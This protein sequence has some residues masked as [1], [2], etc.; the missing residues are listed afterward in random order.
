MATPSYRRCA[1]FLGGV[2]GRNRRDPRRTGYLLAQRLE[3]EISGPG[4]TLTCN[5]IVMSNRSRGESQKS[6]RRAGDCRCRRGDR[7]RRCFPARHAFGSRSNP[8]RAQC[9]SAHDD[10]GRYRSTGRKDQRALMERFSSYLVPKQKRRSDPVE[11]VGL[12]EV[13]LWRTAAIRLLKGSLRQRCDGLARSRRLA[14][15]TSSR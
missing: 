5:Q 13:R 9:L 2:A 15:A 12:V 3:R 14:S 11:N 4:R 10:H 7:S 8:H 6:E 1:A